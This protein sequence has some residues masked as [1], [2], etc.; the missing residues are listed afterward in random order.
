MLLE[1]TLSY[2]GIGSKDKWEESTAPVDVVDRQHGMRT[3]AK[4]CAHSRKQALF[5]TT[6]VKLHAPF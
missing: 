5:S 1:T 6:K 3:F 2:A 4:S